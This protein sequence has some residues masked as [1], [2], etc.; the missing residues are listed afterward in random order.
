[1]KH[2]LTIFAA[3]FCLTCHAQKRK[4]QP[5]KATVDFVLKNEG[6]GGE[7]VVKRKLMYN[8]SGYSYYMAKMEML[9]DSLVVGK[10]ITLYPGNDSCG[11]LF[12]QIRFRNKNIK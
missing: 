11:I 8:N 7:V 5:I 1:M 2:L 10:V 4:P 3:A 9:P 12:K 6:G